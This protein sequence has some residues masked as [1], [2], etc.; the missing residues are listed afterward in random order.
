[1]CSCQDR[2]VLPQPERRMTKAVRRAFEKSA[3][4][5]KSR[6]PG[7]D[8]ARRRVEPAAYRVRSTRLQVHESVRP[9]K[10]SSTTPTNTTYYEPSPHASVV[11]LIFK[12]AV[13]IRILVFYW[14]V[15]SENMIVLLHRCW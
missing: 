8:V 10:G 4:V 1:M 7:R 13:G 14:P 15:I 2:S 3:A 6:R 5:Q 9:R 11:Y 12:D